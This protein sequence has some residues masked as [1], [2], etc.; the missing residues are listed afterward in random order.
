VTWSGSEA[1]ISDVEAIELAFVAQWAHFGQGPFG[2]FHRDGDLTWIEAPVP[3]LPYNAV[4]RAQL[5]EDAEARIDEVIRSYQ[6]RDVQFMWL[7]HP[8]AQPT[9]LARLLARRGLRLVEHGTGMSL[10]LTRWLPSRHGNGAGVTF[11]EVTTESQMAAYEELI[12]HYWE[13]GDAS[14]EYVFG[15]NRWAA[16][17]GH[18]VRFVAFKDGA[19]VGKAYL[20]W[21]LGDDAH[22]LSDATASIYGVYVAPSARGLG[23]AAK[24]MD[25]LLERA[26]ASGR[27]R[28]VLH[29]S[30][31]AIEL[32]LRLGFAARCVLPVYAT[33]SLHSLQPS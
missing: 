13:L 3:E 23:I 4:V 5:G 9:D 11:E 19:P 7:V 30:E 6:E 2:T 31:M 8:T 14:C 32:Y 28:V 22:A 10:D 26:A 18:G 25:L 21:S 12:A 33:T 1:F 29:S 27:R 15:I 20:S 16:E 24:M 17:L